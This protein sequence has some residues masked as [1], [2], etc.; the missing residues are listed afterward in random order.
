MKKSEFLNT[1]KTICEKSYA[2]NDEGEFEYNG[3]DDCE[4]LDAEPIV[5][6]VCKNNYNCM[7]LEAALIDWCDENLWKYAV[8][9]RD[10]W[11]V[12]EIKY[13]KL[14]SYLDERS[15]E[16]FEGLEEI[17]FDNISFQNYVEDVIWR[18]KFRVNVMFSTEKEKLYDPVKYDNDTGFWS[19][20]EGTIIEN[21]VESQ[22]YTLENFYE[23][24]KTK[25][26]ESVFLKSLVDEFDGLA[27]VPYELTA[28]LEMRA[29]ELIYIYEE[30]F[31]NSPCCLTVKAGSSLALTDCAHY[32]STSNLEI[33]L[34]KDFT[35]SLNLISKTQIESDNGGNGLSVLHREYNRDFKEFRTHFTECEDWTVD[36]I[37]GLCHNAWSDNDFSLGVPRVVV[38]PATAVSA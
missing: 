29:D 31:D 2:F 38:K 14:S 26:S 37:C 4:T 17:G 13:S 19:N 27:Y 18:T 3:Y 21:L 15:D 36:D 6:W 9:Q 8:E 28:M 12:N 16:L 5:E 11:L 7:S 34:E 24:Q 33:K 10:N 20:F 23:A 30:T 22:G 32:G 35:V 25:K 1:L